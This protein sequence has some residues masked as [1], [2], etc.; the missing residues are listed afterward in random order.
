MRKNVIPY[1]IM[2]FTESLE[3]FIFEEESKVPEFKDHVQELT[4][5]AYTYL[6]ECTT[7]SFNE[8][9]ADKKFAY[10]SMEAVY[11][12]YPYEDITE[13]YAKFM[14]K[15]NALVRIYNRHKLIYIIAKRLIDVE[16]KPKYK[17][18]TLRYYLDTPIFTVALNYAEKHPRYFPNFGTTA[19][20]YNQLLKYLELRFVTNQKRKG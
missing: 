8:L 18:A 14:E 9:K 5:L 16:E 19:I 7:K 15:R 4:E 1:R 13:S 10:D 2:L 17:L 3:A 12:Q 11:A 20:T 6:V